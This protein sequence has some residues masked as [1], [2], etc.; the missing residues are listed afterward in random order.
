MRT[1]QARILTLRG[2]ASRVADTLDWLET[3][4]RET[5]Q[6]RRASSRVSERPR[7]PAPRS[8][9]PTTPPHCST[10]STPPPAAASNANYADAACP[11]WC[12]PP[13][14]LDNPELAQRL[15][16]GVEPHTPYH[17]HALTT[18]TA[19]LAEAHGDHQAAADGYADA[20]ERWQAFGVIPEQAFALLGHGRCLLALGR[21]ADATPPLQQARDIFA[22]LQAAPALAETDQLLQQAT[23][24]SS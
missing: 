5:G 6:P 14:P 16:T 11:R 15:T 19:A 12:A 17:E 9:N 8:H 18:A 1:V 22:R 4:S 13:S 7:S 2:Q 23:A 24:L 21:P 3:T 10:R 20:A